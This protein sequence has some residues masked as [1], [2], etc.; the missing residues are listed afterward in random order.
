MDIVT[1]FIHRPSSAAAAGLSAAQPRPGSSNA[2]RGTPETAAA[3]LA[4]DDEIP[5]GCGWFDSSHELQCGLLITE[6]D[7][8]DRVAQHLPLDT[9]LAW[10]LA[11]STA[12]GPALR[13]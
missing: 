9:W 7:S 13:A 12:A 3:T 6:H 5:R 11:G 10:H 2:G 4:P 8:P 1:R